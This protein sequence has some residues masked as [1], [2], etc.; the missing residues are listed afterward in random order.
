MNNTLIS[1][2]KFHDI[3]M[4]KKKHKKVE[5]TD[6]MVRRAFNM[7]KQMKKEEQNNERTKKND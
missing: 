4:N 2:I 1:R 3:Q 7:A 6:D 5:I